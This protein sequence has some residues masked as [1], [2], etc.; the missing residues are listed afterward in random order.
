MPNVYSKELYD[1]AVH[2]WQEIDS[3]QQELE[4]R[5]KPIIKYCEKC[6]EKGLTL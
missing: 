1:I 3:R 4:E 6:I 2:S 5:K